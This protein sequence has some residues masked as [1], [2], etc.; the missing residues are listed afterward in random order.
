MADM[1]CAVME[2]GNDI[3]LKISWWERECEVLIPR[4]ALE[5]PDTILRANYIEPAIRA[6]KDDED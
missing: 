2:Y 4:H 1:R 3:G 5:Q 6:M